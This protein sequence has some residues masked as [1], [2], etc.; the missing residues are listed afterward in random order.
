MKT[1]FERFFFWFKVAVVFAMAI[2]F[3]FL[4]VKKTGIGGVSYLT[5]FD[6]HDK[7]VQGFYPEG[8]VE[9]LEGMQKMNS[10]P[11]Y[12][13]VYEPKKFSTAKVQLRYKNSA[14]L[15]AKFGVKLKGGE[16]AFYLVDLAGASADFVEQSFEFN[17]ANT[18]RRNNKIK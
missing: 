9:Q 13:E 1:G 18:E 4:I 16:W 10:E 15:A 5:E 14:K 7:Y 17:L 8:R 12:L 3:C 11:I 6:E 2:I